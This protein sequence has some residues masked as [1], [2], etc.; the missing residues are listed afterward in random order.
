MDL[1]DNIILL[2]VHI[3][4]GLVELSVKIK[5]LH[6]KFTGNAK[7][8]GLTES[9]QSLQSGLHKPGSEGLSKQVQILLQHSTRLH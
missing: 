6:D 5:A 7:V 9:V 8:Q 3:R 1:L 4:G 2:K